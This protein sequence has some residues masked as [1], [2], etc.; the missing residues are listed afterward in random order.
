MSVLAMGFVAC[1]EYD[2]AIPQANEQKPIVEVKGLEV[3]AAEAMAN[4][5]DLNNASGPIELIK[6]VKTP[7]LNENNSIT[8]DVQIASDEN[9]TKMK[10]YQLTDGAIDS[11][12][13]DAAFRQLYGKTPNQKPLYFRFIPYLTDGE[14][15]VL[16]EK[17]VYL[18]ASK[19]DV[20]PVDMGIVVESA[21]YVLTDIWFGDGWEESL[22]PFTHSGADRYDDPIFK[23]TV[24]FEPEID[25]ETGEEKFEPKTLQIIGEESVAKAKED[26]EQALNYVWGPAGEGETGDLAYGEK[27]GVITIAEAGM[28][29]ITI[30]MLNK[31]YAIQKVNPTMY[32]IG[33]HTNWD[34]AQAVELVP[35]NKN[36]NTNGKYW[37]IA[38]VGAGE[39]NGFKFNTSAAWDGGEFGYAGA[40]LVS[41]VAGVNF[42]DDGGNIAVDKAGWYLFGVEK[43]AEIDE[44]QQPTGKY[45]Y[46]VNI[47]TP[48]V[49]VYGNTNGG[50][51]GDDPNWKFSVPADASGEFVSP[52]LAAKGELRLCVHPLTSAGNEW[53]G[54]W[55]QSEFLFFNGEIAYRGQ[56]G[57]QDRVNAEA[58]QKVYLNFTT[59][60]ARLE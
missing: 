34:W 49:Y 18:L 9:F 51:W 29:S 15:R 11:Y 28:Y 12:D 26:P 37:C 20:K 40:T 27:A 6:T 44:E 56:G 10:Q 17:D 14:S 4:P 35:A 41:H 19:N 45:L 43:K 47:F 2:E 21:Y 33:K 32:M 42:V 48:D 60:K 52:A 5:I 46:T 39:S 8:Y 30:D 7:V 55:W 22:V 31:T 58:G 36:T 50:G 59:G 3:T 25:P 57:D 24:Q 13:L 54:E 23:T 53:I 38:Y 16:F 1:D